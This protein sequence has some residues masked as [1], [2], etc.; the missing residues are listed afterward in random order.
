MI[1]RAAGDSIDT[2]TDFGFPLGM[3]CAWMNIETHRPPVLWRTR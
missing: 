2:T 3:T 1:N